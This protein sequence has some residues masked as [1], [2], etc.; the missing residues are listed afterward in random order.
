MLQAT[1]QDRPLSLLFEDPHL[2]DRFAAA[3]RDLPPAALAVANEPVA[4]LAAG[5]RQAVEA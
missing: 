4:Q 3:E 2:R 5:A 1:F